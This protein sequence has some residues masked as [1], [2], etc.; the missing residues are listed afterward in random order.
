MT[1]FKTPMR[2]NIL[3]FDT[4]HS[5][6]YKMYEK[7]MR[8]DFWAERLMAVEKGER[9]RRQRLC[10]QWLTSPAW[11]IQSLL[12][13]Y[14]MEPPPC[15]LERLLVRALARGWSH[16]PTT[17]TGSSAHGWEEQQQLLMPLQAETDDENWND[18]ILSSLFLT[19]TCAEHFI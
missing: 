3:P 4:S 16:T 13:K 5:T 17:Q 8:R 14:L 1:N 6:W 9:F 19:H 11:K 12:F 18:L 7:E 15:Q 10:P 2:K